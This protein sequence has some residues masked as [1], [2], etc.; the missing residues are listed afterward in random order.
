MGLF[1]RFIRV[2][3]SNFNAGLNKIEDPEKVLGQLLI[4]MNQQ[5]IEMKRSVAGAI[6]DEKRI[7][8]QM[9]E[10]L[11]QSR[12]WERRAILALKAGKEDLARE[13]L[14]RKRGVDEYAEQY[15]KQWEQQ[16]AAVEELKNHL[17]ELQ[18]KIEDAGRKKNLLVA[19]AKR[20]EAQKRINET[21]G[22]LNDNSAFEVFDR[23]NKRIDD[24]E[25]ETEALGQLVDSRSSEDDIE[26]QFL[27]LEG[28]KGSTDLML[29]ELKQR[30]ALEGPSDSANDGGPVDDE[31]E[32]LKQ[33]L[34]DDKGDK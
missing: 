29:E 26:K 23:M 31:I 12:E 6:A 8:R 18:K 24:M 28:G 33:R 1:S 30:I 16:H 9:N 32:A 17:K 34:K 10:Q 11:V 21:I 14:E 22:G 4:E 19:R 20:V 3:K 2:I 13:A 7:E 15:R 25:A 27:E 5:L